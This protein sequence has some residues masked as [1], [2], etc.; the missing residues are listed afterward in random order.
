MTKQPSYERRIEIALLD[1]EASLPL[2]T[3]L[4]EL[5]DVPYDTVLPPIGSTYIRNP[6]DVVFGDME[7]L[8]QVLEVLRNMTNIVV[9]RAEMEFV[10]RH[11]TQHRWAARILRSPRSVFGI[12]LRT[13]TPGEFAIRNYFH[14]ALRFQIDKL[15]RALI[16]GHPIESLGWDL[17]AIDRMG[18]TGGIQQIGHLALAENA[19]LGEYKYPVPLSFLGGSDW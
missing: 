12:N 9:D 3:T 4:D 19:R 1:A 5:R 18:F 13:G 14:F 2:D 11:E 15:G 6:G 8:P 10:Q 16:L 7:E 17:E